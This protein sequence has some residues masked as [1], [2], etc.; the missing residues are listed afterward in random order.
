MRG[1]EEQPELSE[2]EAV[3]RYKIRRSSYEA[4]P[5]AEDIVIRD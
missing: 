5:E 4:L 1:S 3:A 2:N